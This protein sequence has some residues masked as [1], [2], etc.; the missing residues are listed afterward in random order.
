MK[1]RISE[2]R[3]QT[4]LTQE[5]FAKR[6]NMS[7]NY[8]WMIEKG[9]RVPADRTIGD[10][11]REFGVNRVW[12]ETGVGD[13]FQPKDKRDELKA[14]FAD[15]LSGRQ[16]EK[17]AFIEAVAQLPDDVFPVLVKSWIAAAEEM[18]QKLKETE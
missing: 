15:V 3:K 8:I 1:N 9:E 4:G 5:E 2:V 11:C 17:N 10:I 7:R 12:L 6:I 16:S 13:P 14:V 18:K